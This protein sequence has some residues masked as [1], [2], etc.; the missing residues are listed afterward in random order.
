MVISSLQTKNEE[1]QKYKKICSDREAIV[2]ERVSYIRAFNLKF[3]DEYDACE[4]KL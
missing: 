4:K 3:Q 1:I 2:K